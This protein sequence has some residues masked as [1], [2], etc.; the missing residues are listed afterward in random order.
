MNVRIMLAAVLLVVSAAA[1]AAE[2]FGI[3]AYGG[4]TKMAH[5]GSA[6]G[7]V[8]LSAISAGSGTYGV[9]AIAGMRGEILLWDGKLLVPSGHA[10][11]GEVSAPQP[12]DAAMLF[13]TEKVAGR[14]ERR[15]P[16]DMTHTQFEAY[17]L[18]A[19]H[20]AGLDATRAFPFVL[21]GDKLHVEWHVVTRQPAAGTGH[22]GSG[23]HQQGH[24]NSKVFREEGAP[25]LLL[26]FH[27]GAALEGTASHPG[28][29]FHVHYADSKLTVS[30]HAD[31]YRV[32]AGTTL[33]LPRL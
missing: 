22:H 7:V 2:P 3:Q 10:A 24:A 11:K 29:R 20:D 25:G 31:G 8:T 33:L 16:R 13:V 15:V 6:D 19:A 14:T 28:E 12:D 17:V 5:T 27:V 21:R 9:G 18:D 1:A 32:P 26:G 4:F 23:V 30:G